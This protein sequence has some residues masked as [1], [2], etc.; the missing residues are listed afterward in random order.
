MSYLRDPHIHILHL[1]VRHVEKR[2]APPA[3]AAAQEL[4]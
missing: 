4:F 3:A 1:H 2:V